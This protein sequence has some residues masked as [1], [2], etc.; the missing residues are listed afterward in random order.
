MK[1]YELKG[2][3]AIVTGGSGGIGRASAKLLAEAGA[4]VAI[5]DLDETNSESVVR[6]IMSAGGNI[7][8]AN[9]TCGTVCGASSSHF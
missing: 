9:Q 1:A 7:Q 6:E 3:K 2:K 4:A 5:V 8:C